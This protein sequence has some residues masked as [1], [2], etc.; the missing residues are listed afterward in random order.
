M[1]RNS[2]KLKNTPLIARMKSSVIFKDL[3]FENKAFN[4]LRVEENKSN[5]PHIV[6]S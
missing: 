5:N 4:S 6:K 2:I 1:F 3:K